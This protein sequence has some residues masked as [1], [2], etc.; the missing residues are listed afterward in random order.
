MN[1]HEGESINRGPSDVVER[2]IVSAGPAE[3]QPPPPDKPVSIALH[4][5]LEKMRSL[6]ITQANIE[7]AEMWFLYQLTSTPSPKS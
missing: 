6:R 1:G 7:L 5:A 4:D 2:E 3:P